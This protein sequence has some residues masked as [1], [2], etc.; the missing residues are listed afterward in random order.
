[1]MKRVV[2]INLALVVLSSLL[3]LAIFE[4]AGRFFLSP[5]QHSYGFLFGR[6]LPP[7]KVIHGPSPLSQSDRSIWHEKLIVGGK[8]ISVDDLWGI[9]REDALLGYAPQ[10]DAISLNGWWQTNNLGARSRHNPSVDVPQG[11]KR[12]LV[13]GDFYAN[14]SR[15]PQEEAWS[16]ILEAESDNLEVINFGVDGYSMGQA[17]LRYLQISEKLSYDITMIM[18][19]PVEDRW[20]DINVMRELGAEGWGIFPIM[21]RF[22]F[23]NGQLKLIRSLYQD[24]AD[25]YT[26]NPGL[27]SEQLKI[28]LM[29]CDSFY[30]T[31]KYE[32]PWFIGRFISYKM[33]ARAHYLT[34]IILLRY[35]TIYGPI[36]HDSEAILVSKK[37]FEAMNT[38][39]RHDGK[40]FILVFLSDHYALDN[41]NCNIHYS[42][43][44]DE[45]VRSI[46][47]NG[48]VCINLAKEMRLFSSNQL[49]KGYDDSHYGPNANR[50]IAALLP[51]FSVSLLGVATTQENYTKVVK[52]F[53]I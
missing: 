8:K 41:V 29:N 31:S 45:M 32:S 13:F 22:F 37:I 49:D 52:V 51:G 24:E 17:F 36:E 35:E 12:L 4:V 16:S 6:E 2:L 5:S 26:S 15:L 47:N 28:H 30:I 1:M 38:K 11:K 53:E 43:K 3:G 7:I 34:K 25:F 14:G 20:R 27:I 48:F 40:D 19:V 9:H 10:E 23:E 39:S 18:F 44:W 50:L 42:R 21:P 33:I 46:C